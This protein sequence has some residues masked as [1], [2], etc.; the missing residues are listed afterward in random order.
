MCIYR[1]RSFPAIQK[2]VQ[3]KLQE[4]LWEGWWHW[5]PKVTGPHASEMGRVD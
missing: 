2:W 3:E 4:A 5:G 1:G